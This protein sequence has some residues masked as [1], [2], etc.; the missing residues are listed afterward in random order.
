MPYDTLG[1]FLTALQD[2]GEVVR[3][4]ATVDPALELS[5]ITDRVAKRSGDGGPVLF[6]ASVRNAHW[7]VVTNVLGHPRR[8]CRA[9]GVESLDQIA[10]RFVDIADE[11][12]PRW[13]TTHAAASKLSSKAIRQAACQQVVKLGRDVN[14]W[15]LPALRNWPGEQ[16][17]AFTG[18]VV[19]TPDVPS[20]RPALSLAPLQLV[21]RHRLL[22][23][24]T[25]VDAPLQAALA[26][27]QAQRQLPIALAFGG[28]PLLTIAAEAGRWLNRS[29]G[30]GAVGQLRRSALE[31]VKCRSHDLEVPADAEVIIE[32][33]IDPDTPWERIGSLGLSTGHYAEETA[34]PPIQ[35]TAITHRANPLFPAVVPNAAPS[36]EAWRREGLDR[37]F[38]PLVKGLAPAIID[39]ARPAGA[40]GNTVFVAIHKQSPLEARTVCH[41]L[42]SCPGLRFARWIIVVD[43]DVP[44][45]REGDVWGA[46]ARNVDPLRD[47]FQADGPAHPDDYA[48]SQRGIG[49]RIA[50][51]ATRKNADEGFP[52]TWPMALR[53]SQETMQKMTERWGEF[54][55]PE[56]W[57]VGS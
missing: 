23:Y 44:L 45:R 24:W 37:L 20:G 30:Y 54:G 28:D 33:F 6:F 13:S 11:L 7:P 47:C 10:T 27:R 25:S 4:A 56:R 48:T 1:D 14:L 50:V 39:Y 42:W 34:V 21:D 5:A 8:L 9:L 51:D 43:E 2:T 18:G 35:V 22:P 26:A 55:L 53:S 15:E 12:A 46:V 41:A 32:G 49:G 31:V 3:I 57:G 16:N 38:L 40:C 17:P 36:E 29:A 19:V 52:R